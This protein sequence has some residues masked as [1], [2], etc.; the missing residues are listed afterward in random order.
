MPIMLACTAKR[1]K[2]LKYFL[3]I[4]VS[5]ICTQVSASDFLVY[6]R[7]FTKPGVYVPGFHTYFSD[8]YTSSDRNVSLLKTIKKDLVPVRIADFGSNAPGKASMVCRASYPVHTPGKIPFEAFI[9]EAMKA[10]LSEAGLYSETGAEIT[11]NLNAIEFASFGV[12]KWTIEAT[13]AV[14]GKEPLKVKHETTYPVSFGAVAA[15][16][17]VTQALVPAI[18]EFLYQFYSSP[19]FKL[20][21]AS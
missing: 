11:A 6:P 17:D 9:A 15:C 10:E 2:M 13:F 21:L 7:G 14:E 1:R 18:Q 12:G 5:L 19:Q 4:L 3:A 20:L 16:D 8:K